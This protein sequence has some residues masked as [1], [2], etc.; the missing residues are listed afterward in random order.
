MAGDWIKVEKVTARKPEVL[1]VADKLAIHPYHAFGLCVSFWSWCDD[2]MSDGH[3]LRVTDVTLDTVFG[4]AGFTSALLSVGWL[5]VRNGSLAVPNFDRHLSESAKARA[6]SGNRKKIQRAR[7][8]SQNVSR[9]QRDKNGTSLLFSCISSSVLDSGIRVP[10]KLLTQEFADNWNRWV[11][12][13]SEIR[14]PLKPTQV[15]SQLAELEKVGLPKAIEIIR[16]TIAK[17]WIGLRD[18][19]EDQKPGKSKSTKSEGFV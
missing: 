15:E 3:A 12:H 7:S 1:A 2:Q 8:A 19:D 9:S 18:P 14:K 17:G 5:Q 13:R 11:K 16:H 4:H 6:L 10:E